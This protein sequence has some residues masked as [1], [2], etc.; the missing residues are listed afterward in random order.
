LP[1]ALLLYQPLPLIFGIAGAVRG[2]RNRSPQSGI[3]RRLSLWAFF[4]LLLPMLYPGRQVS[5]LVWML[6][7]VWA[8]A[9]TELAQSLAL[10][11]QGQGRLIIAGQAALLFLLSTFAW[12]YLLVM[13]N[14]RLFA[15]QAALR[16]IVILLVAAIGMG[17]VTTVL[18]SLG[19]SWSFARRGLVWG[20]SI[21]LGLY[22]LAAM[23]GSSQVR[24]AGAQELWSRAP[25]PGETDLLART[26]ADL[27]EW[28][29]GQEKMLDIL[30]LADNPSLRWVLRSWPNAKYASSLSPGE[31]PSIIIAY[32]GQEPPALAASYRGQDFPW[33]AQPA[34]PGALP[35]DLPRW[36]A[37][38]DAEGRQSE[39][40]L[41]ARTDLFPGGVF[42]PQAEIQVSPEE[43]PVP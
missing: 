30:V 37:F 5:D 23:W 19:W 20:L 31:Q 33:E 42:E 2:W 26:L 1:F 39:I 6:I 15:G 7:P 35:A 24:P 43:G 3:A 16:N 38:R 28:H 41:W 8:L 18:V 22:M 10:E 17:A 34:W 32:S 13:T 4:A 21:S 25:S 29:T 36:L 9:A 40:I 27:S 11:E 14:A 12:N